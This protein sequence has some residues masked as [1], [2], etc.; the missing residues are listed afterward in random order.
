MLLCPT[1]AG[2]IT[3]TIISK[4]GETL[5]NKESSRSWFCVLNNPQEIYSGEPNE[6]AEKCLED[7]VKESPTRTGAVAYCISSDNLIHLHMVLED[8]NKARFSA[9]KHIY[10]KAHL[11]PTKG[12]KEQ[13]E[14]YINKTGKFQEKG[15]KIIYIARYGEIKGS[16]GQRNDLVIIEE[17]LELG[18]TPNEIFEMSLAFRKYDRIIRDAYY[19]KRAKETPMKRKIKVFWHFGE[20]GS[21]KKA[22]WLLN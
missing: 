16:Q 17:L 19:S 11:E 18:K 12:T 9:L 22:I 5:D 1:K 2:S 10:T 7:W 8:S 14:A 6:I 21:G 15:E 4:G 3:G 13:A 20:A